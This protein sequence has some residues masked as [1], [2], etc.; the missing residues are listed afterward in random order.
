MKNLIFVMCFLFFG[1]SASA[2]QQTTDFSFGEAYVY[3]LKLVP[4]VNPLDGGSNVFPTAGTTGATLWY[5]FNACT[6]YGN[7]TIFVSGAYFGIL[8]AMQFYGNTMILS[9]KKGLVPPTEIG[10]TTYQNGWVYTGVISENTGK[11]GTP[12]HP[13]K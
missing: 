9:F 7:T 8:E 6:Q 1:I 3:K 2:Q 10:Q 4:Y 12:C 13:T 5:T 11:T